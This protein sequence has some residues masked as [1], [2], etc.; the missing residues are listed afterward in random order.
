MRRT[1]RL[2]AQHF[3]LQLGQL[4]ALAGVGR[5]S[6][7]RSVFAF[8]GDLALVVRSIRVV[9]RIWRTLEAFGAA[10]A[11]RVRSSRSALAPLRRVHQRSADI[12]RQHA[13]WLRRV[14]PQ[15]ADISVAMCPGIR[16]DGRWRP[17]LA[18]LR[19]RVDSV[20]R[21]GVA[22][23]LGL[24][25]IGSH[26][27]L[28]LSFVGQVSTPTAKVAEAHGTAIER[29]L[30]FPHR[31]VPRAVLERLREVGMRVP[32]PVEQDIRAAGMAAALRHADEVRAAQPMLQGVRGQRRR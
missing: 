17:A 25:H 24:R 13:L 14:C 9:P 19:S 12:V 26:I 18:K 2:S 22:P 7:P 27:M 28:V 15:W 30:H 6:W 3:S 10:T 20:A 23:S 5:R 1:A 4:A 32:P 31:S 11:L 29:I 21:C 8:A 16:L